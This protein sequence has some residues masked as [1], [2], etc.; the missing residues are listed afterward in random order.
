MV[1]LSGSTIS[2]AYIIGPIMAGA[3]TQFV[4]EK[5]TFVVVG[6]ILAPVSVFLLVVT[7]EKLRLPQTEIKT[8]DD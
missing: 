7:P 4:G 2:V 1:G 3:I 6:N 5:N 8:W